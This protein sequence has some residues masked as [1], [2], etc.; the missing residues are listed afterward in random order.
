MARSKTTAFCS[1][2][3][4]AKARPRCRWYLGVFEFTLREAAKMARGVPKNTADGLDPFSPI[5]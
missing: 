1:T 2:T 5:L 4:Q 3:E